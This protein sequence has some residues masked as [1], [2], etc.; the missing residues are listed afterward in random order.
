MSR[1][2]LAVVT[3]LGEVFLSSP[4][5]T[6]GIYNNLRWL[7]RYGRCESFK[8]YICHRHY[9]EFLAEWEDDCFEDCFCE[10]PCFSVTVANGVEEMT[11]KFYKRICGI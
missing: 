5:T 1:F 8:V 7:V 3:N 4:C 9:C 11:K 10:Y 2:N 6:Q